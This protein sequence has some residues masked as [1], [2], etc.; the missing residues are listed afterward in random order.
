MSWD[1]M[2]RACQDVSEEPLHPLGSSDTSSPITSCGKAGSAGAA[3]GVTGSR[4][5]GTSLAKPSEVLEVPTRKVFYERIGS[6][7]SDIEAREEGLGALEVGCHV[8]RGD[9]EVAISDLQRCRSLEWISQELRIQ[10]GRC[11]FEL[12]AARRMVP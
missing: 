4:S 8:M 10:L 1:P 5:P 6:T 12:I 9:I 3:R 7:V 2:P 11:L